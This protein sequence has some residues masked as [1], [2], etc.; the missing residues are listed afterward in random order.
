MARYFERAPQFAAARSEG[1]M[2]IALA[3]SRCAIESLEQRV[4]LSIGGLDT[5]FGAGGKIVFPS[6]DMAWFGD[7]VVLGDDKVLAIANVQDRQFIFAKYKLDGL[8][9][10][11]FAYHGE[12]VQPYGWKGIQEGWGLQPDGKIIFAYHERWPSDPGYDEILRYLPDGQWDRSFG[13]KGARR[14]VFGPE[15][16]V[17]TMLVL[18][19]GGILVGA[20]RVRPTPAFLLR[21]Y[22]VDGQPDLSF[23]DHGIAEVGLPS[24]GGGPADEQFL[25]SI[26]MSSLAIQPDGK[27]VV[28]GSDDEYD[29]SASLCY[30]ARFSSDGQP[31]TSFG[32]SGVA[33]AFIRA[34]ERHNAWVSSAAFQSDG[35]IIVSASSIDQ[36]ALLLRFQPDGTLDTSF[37]KD[38]RVVPLRGKNIG[39]FANVAIQPDDAI[40]VGLPLLVGKADYW[41]DRSA[42]VL[43]GRLSAD[44]KVDKTFGKNGFTSTDFGGDDSISSITI[45]PDGGILVIGSSQGSA[46]FGES[47]V[48]ARFM[49]QSSTSPA[50]IKLAELKYSARQM[51]RL[52]YRIADYD[53]G[54]SIAI[55]SN[56][57]TIRS[58]PIDLVVRAGPQIIPTILKRMKQPDLPFDT[59]TRCY[60]AADQIITTANP[61]IKPVYWS[62]DMGGGTDGNGD[63]ILIP[64]SD[65]GQT[66][67]ARGDC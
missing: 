40:V 44:G 35:S 41:G 8:P 15:S 57:V 54:E 2:S 56:R 51:R 7:G 66:F 67:R 38:G 42:D 45:Q 64:G 17:S 43:V 58:R 12:M 16:D 46:G 14:I 53:P 4:F 13:S 62:G 61:R 37:G 18:P 29:L 22:D 65:V 55:N 9:D 1:L 5:T 24:E 31:D 3:Q 20:V 6:V 52:V 48:L 32:T 27:I 23:G 34:D 21:R 19:D 39:D 63:P 25:K 28:V 47:L 11:S 50:N 30:L 49:G 26:A 36:S 33:R 59:F 10:P 60:T